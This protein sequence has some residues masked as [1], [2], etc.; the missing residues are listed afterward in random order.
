MAEN[1]NKI[2][3]YRD[4][5]S[6][7]ESLSDEEA[8]KLIKHLFRYVNDL[9]PEAPDRLTALLFEPIKQTLKRDLKAYQSK[10]LKNRDNVN[11][12]W[13]TE[14]TN[15]YERIQ[16]DTNHTDNDNDNDIDINNTWKKNF[17]IYLSDCKK[18]Y[19]SFMNNPELIKTQ[20][21]L[22]PGINIALSVEK[23]F[24]NFWS[25]EAGWKH[26]KKSR[27]KEIDWQST[28][29]NSINLNKVYYTKQELEK[30]S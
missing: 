19:E 8:G 29:I 16:P 12:R 21:R 20:Q 23:G 22:N 7:F 24:V 4:W 17:S 25:T 30:A 28:I 1:K 26:K 10:C 27:S 15:V 18:A 2:I 13:N 6:T 3:V 5:I 9:N 11:V 14:N